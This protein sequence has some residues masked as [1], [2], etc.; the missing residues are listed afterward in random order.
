MSIG[1]EL[2]VGLAAGAAV[3]A[4]YFLW[5]WWALRRL[6]DRRRAGFWFAAHLVLRFA[7]AL[8]G[9]ALLARGGGLPTVAAGLAGFVAARIWLTRRLPIPPPSPERPT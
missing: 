1:I 5:L 9:F 3:G 8:A 4:L 2:A 7:F 6:V